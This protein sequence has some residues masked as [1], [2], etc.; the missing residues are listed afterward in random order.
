MACT[1][2]LLSP[3]ITGRRGEAPTLA[4][5]GCAAN[6]HVDAEDSDSS[7]VIATGKCQFFFAQI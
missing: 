2:A 3:Y 4:A 7:D 1:S 6:L 5:S